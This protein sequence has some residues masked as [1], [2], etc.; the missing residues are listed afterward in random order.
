M[1]LKHK[2][3]SLVDT[4]DENSPLIKASKQPQLMLVRFH[5]RSTFFK[6]LKRNKLENLMKD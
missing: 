5:G 1:S 2:S 6:N 3:K 4:L